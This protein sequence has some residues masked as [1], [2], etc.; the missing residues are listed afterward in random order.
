MLVRCFYIRN[1]DPSGTFYGLRVYIKTQPSGADSLELAVDTLGISTSDA[2]TLPNE[3]TAPTNETFTTP[4]QGSP[5]SIGDLGAGQFVAIW[6][7]RIVPAETLISTPL[8][9]SSIGVEVSI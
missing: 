2:E 6:V 8:D 7:K 5:L 4:T 3:N 9:L 1:T